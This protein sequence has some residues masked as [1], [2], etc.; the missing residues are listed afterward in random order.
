M[1]NMSRHTNFRLPASPAEGGQGGRSEN[2]VAQHVATLN[3]G[4][5]MSRHQFSAVSGKLV[6]NSEILFFLRLEPLLETSG[7]PF[8]IAIPIRYLVYLLYGK[9]FFLGLRLAI[10]SPRLPC[11]RAP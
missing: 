7:K 4:Y 8:F 3:Q 11:V 9:A 1:L 10:P 5:E 6:A 2:L